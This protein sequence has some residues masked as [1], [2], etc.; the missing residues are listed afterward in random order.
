M[1]PARS[2]LSR[3]QTCHFLVH[4]TMLNQGVFLGGHKGR[5]GKEVRG[6]FTTTDLPD[7]V[8]ATSSF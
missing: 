4:G 1:A 3:N 5:H 7:E 2:P 8:Q 6:S